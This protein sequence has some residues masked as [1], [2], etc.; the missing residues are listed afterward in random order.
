[1]LVGVDWD[2][3]AEQKLIIILTIKIA[4]MSLICIYIQ[5]VMDVGDPFIISFQY[6]CQ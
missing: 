4:E 5:S 2:F 3:I 1:M 6:F